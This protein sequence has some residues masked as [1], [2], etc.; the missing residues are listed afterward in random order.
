[1]T[2]DEGNNAEK[3]LNLWQNI[4]KDETCDEKLCSILKLPA[5]TYSIHGHLK[6][7]IYV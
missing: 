2:L 7:Y 3:I 4:N 6:R 1:M 5:T